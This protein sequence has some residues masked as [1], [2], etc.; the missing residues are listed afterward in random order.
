[1]AKV[2]K[3]VDVHLGC[4]FGRAAKP[5]KRCWGGFRAC[6][7]GAPVDRDPAG[8]LGV[9]AKGNPRGGGPEV[10]GA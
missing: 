4:K 7:K 2:L 5:R 9:G 8:G 1:M 10:A 3:C 6:A